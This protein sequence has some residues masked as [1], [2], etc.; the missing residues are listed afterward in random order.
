MGFV[1]V[2]EERRDLELYYSLVIIV[3]NSMKNLVLV[4][5]SILSVVQAFA[6]H[7]TKGYS[8]NKYDTF[9]NKL[10][11][12]QSNRYAA[13]KINRSMQIQAVNTVNVK[14]ISV[15]TE[16]LCQCQGEG[17]ESGGAADATLDTL[18]SLDLSFPIDDVGC[19]GA[20]GMGSMV[21]IDY[22][23]G[24]SVLVD[25]LQSTLVELGI[26]Q[27]SPNVVASTSDIV[28]N[29]TS[30]KSESESVA[31]SSIN[32]RAVSS[33]STTTS[34]EESET[35]AAVKIVTQPKLDDVR[36]RMRKE[37][38]DMSTEVPN[39][40]LNMASYL[41]KKAFGSTE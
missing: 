6:P 2:G 37:A 17:Y 34:I 27:E 11:Y 16:E 31:S 14:R 1:I 35:E 4:L 20:C 18:Q 3:A 33:S 38:A 15:C 24:D 12:I 39:P 36:D 19:L 5:S 9:P 10:C 30:S 22:E 28:D 26:E 21:A 7:I 13:K 32:E 8:K 40:W 41:A 29:L 25:G 23:N